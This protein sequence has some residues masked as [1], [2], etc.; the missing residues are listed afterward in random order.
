MPHRIKDEDA[1]EAPLQ[2]AE[3]QQSGNM[4]CK[5]LTAV[6]FELSA[7]CELAPTKECCFT[8]HS[9]RKTRKPLRRPAAL[10][11]AQEG[12]ASPML[13]ELAAIALGF[14]R[15]KL[16]SARVTDEALVDGLGVQPRVRR[17]GSR[18]AALF[19]VPR[20]WGR[21]SRRFYGIENVPALACNYSQALRWFALL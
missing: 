6:V 1:L 20:E 7:F 21:I 8:L 12:T 4:R 10:P 15:D 14:V 3:T 5:P 11:S 9:P 2:M 17:L 19:G 13:R 18:S 16:Q